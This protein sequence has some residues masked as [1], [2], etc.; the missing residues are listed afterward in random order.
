MARAFWSP[1]EDM[2]ADLKPPMLA[3]ESR[4]GCVPNEV[5][6]SLLCNG[7]VCLYFL[8]FVWW[9]FGNIFMIFPYEFVMDLSSLA[10]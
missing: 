4:K 6:I 2:L 9:I 8:G 3:V 5:C 1:D 7:F 10:P